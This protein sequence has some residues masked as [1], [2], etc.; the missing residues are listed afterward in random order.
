MPQANI[1]TLLGALI[2]GVLSGVIVAV[3]SY[4][5]TRR[6]TLAEIKFIE[7]Q[8]EKIK[9][10]LNQSVDNI[11]SA[12]TY[13]IA[14]SAERIIYDST[15]RDVGYDFQGSE[16]QIWERIDGVDRPVSGFGRGQLS[17]EKGVLNI[18]R[19]N[20]EGR[21]EVWLQAY[22]FDGHQLQ[23]IPGNDLISGLRGIRIGFEA[24][25]VGA[26]HTLRVLL[27]NEKS[28][29]WLDDE[30]RTISSNSWTPIAIYFQIPPADQCRLRIDDLDVTDTPSS[31]QIRNLVLA[32]RLS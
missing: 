23:S 5:L 22:F 18:Q 14:G 7:A 31:V 1:Y 25:A 2:S 13:K 29:R 11:S 26:S 24:K 32:E 19:S 17:L 16:A 21:F 30:S 4:L 6:K 12:V 8:Y 3:L 15:G 27:K 10:E 20:T 9:R 28:N